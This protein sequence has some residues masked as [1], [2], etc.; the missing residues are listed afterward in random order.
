MIPLIC[1]IRI[2]RPGGR[3]FRIW[4]PLFLLW[5]LIIALFAV[6]E[7]L[8]ILACVVLL[9]IW[10]REAVKLALA[11]PAA[12]Y[13]LFQATGLQVEIAEPG[14]GEVLVQLS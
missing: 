4:I 2:E 10:P 11:L 5:P 9:F 13:V 6:V 12:V 8:V 7:L 1:T 14:Q 3:R